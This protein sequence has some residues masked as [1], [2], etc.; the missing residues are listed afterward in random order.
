MSPL[1]EHAIFLTLITSRFFGQPLRCRLVIKDDSGKTRSIDWEICNGKRL[2]RY[3]FLVADCCVPSE[4]TE[5]VWCDFAS[6]KRA[7]G[8]DFDEFSTHRADLFMCYENPI[9]LNKLIISVT[10]N[11]VNPDKY[12]VR[13]SNDTRRVP[14]SS[15]FCYAEQLRRIGY[16]AKRAGK[17]EVDPDFGNVIPSDNSAGSCIL[18]ALVDENGEVY[19]FRGDISITHNGKTLLKATRYMAIDY[20]RLAA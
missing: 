14:S 3:W 18:T 7:M 13:M 10:S 11:E 15:S 12:V 9:T 5:H 8:A 19:A 16:R 2:Q 20:E 6:A 1:F 17:K 4:T